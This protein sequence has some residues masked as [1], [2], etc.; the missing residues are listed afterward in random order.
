MHFSFFSFRPPPEMGV[1]IFRERDGLVIVMD[2]QRRRSITFPAIRNFANFPVCWEGDYPQPI[3]I[4][5]AKVRVK[6][7]AGH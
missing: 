3:V 2:R 4:C 7:L 1:I 5:V 6:G